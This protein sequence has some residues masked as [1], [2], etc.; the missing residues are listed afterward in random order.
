MTWL[1]PT[2]KWFNSISLGVTIVTTLG[3]EQRVC[4]VCFLSWTG[5]SWLHHFLSWLCTRR[6]NL[7]SEANRTLTADGLPWSAGGLFLRPCGKCST[8]TRACRWRSTLSKQSSLYELYHLWVPLASLRDRQNDLKRENKQDGDG[9][10][11]GRRGKEEMMSMSL[12]SRWQ[13][14]ARSWTAWSHTEGRRSQSNIWY[15][16]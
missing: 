10:E 16:S 9:G 1:L 8:R 14:T 5:I 4:R 13:I 6:L 7:I 11:R 12:Y 3:G 2:L 15:I